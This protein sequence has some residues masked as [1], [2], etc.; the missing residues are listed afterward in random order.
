[1]QMDP[2]PRTPK[3][4]RTRNSVNVLIS[5]VKPV[6]M[7]A[8]VNSEQPHMKALRRPILSETSPATMPPNI[9]PIKYSDCAGANSCMVMPNVF[10]TDGAT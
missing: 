6:R 7:V 8:M 3:P 2:V 10:M 1:M 4:V 9:M 5:L